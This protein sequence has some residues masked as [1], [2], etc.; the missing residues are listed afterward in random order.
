MPRTLMCLARHGETNWNIE[1]RF[2]GQFDIGLNARGRAQAEALARELAGAHFDRVYSSDLRRALTTAAPIAGARGLEVRATQRLREKDDGAWQGHTHAEV[3]VKYAEVY[4]HYLTRK[5]DF[6]APEGESL[7]QFAGRVRAVLTDI[8]RESAGL[9]ILVVAHAGVLD[10][11]WRMA[12]GKALSEK[13]EHPVLNATPNWVA[14]EDGRWSL[15]DWARPDG[16]AE[17]AAPWDGLTLPRREAAR[18]LIVNPKG[19]ALLM[20]YAGGLSPHFL[21]LGHQHFWATPGGALKEGESFE[22]A[23]RRELREETGLLLS[24]EPGP[25]VA[26]REFPMELGEDWHQAVERYFL[27]RTQ[28]F[29]PSPMNLTPEEKLHTLGW[30]WW[31]ADAIAASD[32]LIF[33]EGLEALLRKVNS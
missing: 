18:A 14:F 17:I 25:V 28:G 11:A 9:T 27:V 2:Q 31:S 7:E 1:R 15:V 21:A 13:R 16:R 8:A 26:T 29:E 6:A 30:R 10:I 12:T 32:E 5:A 3:Q 33:P 20:Q 22:T 24:G 4:P 23:L 19:E